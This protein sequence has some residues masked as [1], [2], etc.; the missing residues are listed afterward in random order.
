M[1]K[2]KKEIVIY[3][4]VSGAIKLKG[5]AVKQTIWATQ[6]QMAVIFDVNSQAITK[7]LKNIYKENELKKYSTCSRME[8]VQKEGGRIISRSVLIYNLD[9]IISV[10][11]RISSKKGTKFRRWA[12][13]VLREHIIKGYTINPSRIKNNYNEFLSAI[14]K[15][16]F[17]LPE[18]IKPDTGSILELIKVFA[19]TWFSLSAYDKE[20]FGKERI[21]KKQIGLTASELFLAIAEFKAEL[22]NKSEATDIFAQERSVGSIEGIVGNIMQSF[23]DKDVYFGVEEKAAHLLYFMV[24]N[25][26]FID[27]NKRCGAFSFIWFLRRNG[28]LN[29]SRLTPAALTALTLL[30]AESNPKEKD[31][32]TGLVS[33]LLRK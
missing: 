27:G 33:M 29:I 16:K 22:F 4:T 18:N 21:T 14:D 30:I 25:H 12:T 23:G 1:K 32:M 31:K 26:P 11:Y 17:L 28:L 13:K 24:K 9:A 2:I 20:I 7:H 15:V 19:E 10:G 3:Q 6:A 5:D 8:Q